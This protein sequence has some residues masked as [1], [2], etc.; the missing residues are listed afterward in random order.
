LPGAAEREARA[1]AAEREARAGARWDGSESL[2]LSP[3]DHKYACAMASMYGFH[4]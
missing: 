4:V 1:G 3:E 2:P